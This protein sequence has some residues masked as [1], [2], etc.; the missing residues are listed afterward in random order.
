LKK[1]TLISALIIFIIIAL[2]PIA[3]IF[4]DSLIHNGEFSLQS[5][6]GILTEDRQIMLFANSLILAG[7][8]AF[9]SLIIGVP[10]GFLIA[11]TNIYFRKY[12]KYL[13]LTPLIIPPHV[14]AIAWI[15]L[16]GTK[17]QLNELFSF[18]I[19]G[20]KGAILV[21]TL[22]YFPIITLFTL[23][24]LKNMDNRLEEAGMMMTS[25]FH[26]LRK[27]TLPLI[28]PNIIA[29]TILVMIFAISNYGVPSLLRL[30][31][32]PVEIFVQFSAFYDSEKAVALSLPLMLIIFIFIT[33]QYNYTKER[34]FI[35]I[36]SDRKNPH[37]LALSY[38]RIPCTGFVIFVML[39]SAVIPMFILI[40]ESGSLVAFK[41]AFK[42]AHKQILNSFVLSFTAATLTVIL[43]FFISYILEKT[44]W[45][46]REILDSLCFIPF[47]IPGAI[48]GIGLIKIWN[49][50]SAN[51]IYESFIIV[52]IAYV[53]RF[54]FL[55]IKTVSGNIRQINTNLEDA[56]IL[57][58][59][60]WITRVLKIWFPLAKSGLLAGWSITFICCM[61]DLGT[62]MLVVP[63]GKETLSIRIYTLM[64]Y[65]A[66]N[67]VACLCLILV[68]MTL[69]SVSVLIF[70]NSKDK[71]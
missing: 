25:R 9:F 7:A 27:I 14:H 18:T 22:S 21:L 42:T 13:Y 3:W 31:T 53:A 58:N 60:S 52:I 48:L 57:S 32:Y 43:S 51:L 55:S 41:I 10:L 68:C 66:G 54:G 37:I 24:G 16:L 34:P 4:A 56:A 1:F 5:Y 61:G 46:G 63:P 70:M 20:I 12:F 47:A 17:G 30:N 39:L 65:G 28:M 8:A 6:K 50:P 49:R 71:T 67:L 40:T 2:L 64:H 26:V 23:S 69:L 45:R 19:Y 36:G 11:R 44:R 35:I 38:W 29:G 62:T 33:I 59:A 15:Y